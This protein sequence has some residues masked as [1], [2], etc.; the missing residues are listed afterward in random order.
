MKLPKRLMKPSDLSRL[1]SIV[2]PILSPDGNLAAFATVR[3]SEDGEGYI[4]AVQVMDVLTREAVSWQSEAKSVRSLAFSPDGR[5]LA[6][7]ESDKESERIVLADVV[8]WRHFAETR[9]EVWSAQKFRG[10]LVW[11][12]DD[13]MMAVTAEKASP[14]IRVYDTLLFKADGVGLNDSS[15][16]KIWRVPLH[17][18]PTMVAQPEQ[19]VLE[20]AVSP[21]G[22]LTA[23]T[24]HA[25][26]GA[27]IS[28]QDIHILD[29]A[30]GA[31]R[32]L[33]ESRGTVHAV[34]FSPDGTK[35]VWLGHQGPEWSVTNQSVWWSD[36]ATGETAKLVPSFDRPAGGYGGD[37][38]CPVAATS[39]PAFDTGKGGTV[40]GIYFIA[41]DSGSTYVYRFDPAYPGTV[42]PVTP[43]N[44]FVRQISRVVDRTFLYVANNETQPDELFLW[45][46]GQMERL[47][48]LNDAVCEELTFA[49][50]EKIPF[51]GADGWTIDGWLMRPVTPEG[52]SIDGPVPLLLV[53]HG[54]PHGAFGN[55]FHW[56]FQNYCAAGMAVAYVNP[57]G[58]QTYGQGFADAVRGDW[59]G[60]DYEDLMAF[61][62][63][64]V[65]D[66]VADAERLGV[67]GYSYGGFMTTWVISHTDRF[68]AAAAGACVSDLVSFAGSSDIGFHFTKEEHFATVWEDAQKLWAASPM[69]Y[70]QNVHTPVLMYCAEDDHRCPIGQTEE[71]YT[72]LKALGKEAVLVRYPHGS[73]GHGFGV[74][75]APKLKMDRIERVR[76]W[77]AERLVG[78]VAAAEVAA[79]E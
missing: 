71:F 14:D 25:A 76:T 17:G 74:H 50:P 55:G 57:R 42:V 7:M 30:S 54:G 20:W 72:A 5:Q 46:D 45:R 21:D 16:T 27:S 31:A 53:I 6:W 73:G 1:T 23:Y 26:P 61:V 12:A 34:G 70:V 2:H 11:L 40:R 22:R 41:A 29:V 38:V 52:R 35:V 8:D 10:G 9:R 3:A 78:S 68:R 66:G 36:V 64:L 19:E 48:H 28:V 75:G 58:S 32:R 62:D 49:A 51:E 59:G 33:F 77:F 43:P 44:G 13:S 56:D 39:P 4:Y 65:A 18:T 79:A 69:A 63:R 37:S 60:K 24:A 47:T 67:T 15:I